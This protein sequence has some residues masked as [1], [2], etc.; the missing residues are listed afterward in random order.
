MTARTVDVG[1]GVTLKVTG[2][3]VIV[4][5]GGDGLALLSLDA[6]RRIWKDSSELAQIIDAR[7]AEEEQ[8]RQYLVDRRREQRAAA[9]KNAAAA[10]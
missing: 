9:R 1:S 7:L 4:Y 10:A 3:E 5:E 8:R 6:T 2:R